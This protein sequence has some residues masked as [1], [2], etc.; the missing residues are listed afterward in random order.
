MMNYSTLASAH[1]RGVIVNSSIGV[2]FTVGREAISV[3][4]FQT[5]PPLGWQHMKE[6]PGL[7]SKVLY[8]THVV[9]QI[10][11]HLLVTPPVKSPHPIKKAQ[12]VSLYG[13]GVKKMLIV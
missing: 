7:R 1:Q 10:Q 8:A 9:I 2:L 13:K 5:R 11:F 4:S 12:M 3:V 6:S